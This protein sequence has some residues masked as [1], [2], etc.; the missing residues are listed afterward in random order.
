[1]SPV[2]FIDYFELIFSFFFVKFYSNNKFSASC[3][4][5]FIAKKGKK[6]RFLEMGGEIS[7]NSSYSLL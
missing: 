2:I 7:E 6:M 4:C 3:L 1:M 5:T